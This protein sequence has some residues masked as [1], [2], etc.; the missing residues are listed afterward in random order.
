MIND[1]PQYPLHINL[2]VENSDD[3]G[4]TD[5]QIEELI[6]LSRKYLLTGS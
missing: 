3:R 1:P 4:L 2:I 6:G 5:A